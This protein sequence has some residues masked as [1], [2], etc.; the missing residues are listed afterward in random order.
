MYLGHLLSPSPSPCSCLGI[1][2]AAPTCTYLP[3][4]QAFV[5]CQL[6]VSRATG[7]AFAKNSNALFMET[8]AKDGSNVH[9]LFRAI[10]IKIK[11]LCN[12][13][14]YTTFSLSPPFPIAET[15]PLDQIAIS[16]KIGTLKLGQSNGRTKRGCCS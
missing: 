10:G 5:L 6:Q 3:M 16:N 2:L 14:Y 1:I 13:V 7:E 8:S 9:D 11:C 15:L 12:F 4:Y